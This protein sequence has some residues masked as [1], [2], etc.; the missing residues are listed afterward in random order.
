MATNLRELLGMVTTESVKGLAVSD[1]ITKVPP[2]P[3]KG[4]CVMYITG[5]CG[6]TCQERDNNYSYYDYPDWQVPVGVTEI[7][8][9]I[10]YAFT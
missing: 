3:S 5:Q 8:F 4:M 10:F 9:E 7:I 6:A 2:F 1:P